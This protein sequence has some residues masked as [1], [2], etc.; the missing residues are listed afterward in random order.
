MRLI[1]EVIVV[2]F[3][4]LYSIVTKHSF[5]IL[6][7]N[8]PSVEAQSFNFYAFPSG[9]N[10]LPIF[11]TKRAKQMRVDNHKELPREYKLHNKKSQILT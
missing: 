6:F 3:A 7:D 2:W 4:R 8:M 9:E 10:Y 1:D 11:G 5:I